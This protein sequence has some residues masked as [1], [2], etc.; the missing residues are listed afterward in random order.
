VFLHPICFY[1]IYDMRRCCPMQKNKSMYLNIIIWHHLYLVYVFD[2]TN[3]IWNIW[4]FHR[5]HQPSYCTCIRH[6][7]H[8]FL[9]SLLLGHKIEEILEWKAKGIF[10]S[11]RK[12]ILN[13]ISYNHN[14]SLFPSLCTSML[15]ICFVSPRSFIKSQ[16]C[17]ACNKHIINIKPR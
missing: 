11:F 4:T 6:M 9:S 3:Y 13:L 5:N 7:K 2:N 12:F 1:Q 8:I 10:T 14:L 16:P 17:F 15:D